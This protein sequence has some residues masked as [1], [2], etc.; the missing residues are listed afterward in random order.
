MDQDTYAFFLFMYYRT[1]VD[2]DECEEW[3]R[4]RS[5]GRLCAG[6]CV[7]VPGSYKC[8][9]PTGYRLSEDKRTCIGKALML[10]DVVFNNNNGFVI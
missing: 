9:C 2:I 6:T 3:A 8:A 7:N 5:R 4:A 1:C 10:V